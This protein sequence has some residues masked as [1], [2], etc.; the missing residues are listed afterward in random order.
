M[1]HWLPILLALG[2]GTGLGWFFGYARGR[3]AGKAQAQ[4]ELAF[5][6]SG[7]VTFD[8]LSGRRAS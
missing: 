6:Q 1:K 2:A 3:S 4:E 5:E 8:A 7:E